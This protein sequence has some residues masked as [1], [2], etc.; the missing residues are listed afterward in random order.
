[1]NLV[2]FKVQGIE[3]LEL[4]NFLGF[5]W[6]EDK[7][8]QIIMNGY[9][10]TLLLILDGENCEKNKKLVLRFKKYFDQ[11]KDP[12]ILKVLLNEILYE[13]IRIANN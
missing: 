4:K 7:K 10:S 12:I 1:M 3:N 13:N 5:G 9:K 8:N 11:V 6:E 2:I